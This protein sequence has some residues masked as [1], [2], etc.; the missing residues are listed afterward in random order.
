MEE[1]IE[2]IKDFVKNAKKE[3]LLDLAER[4][5]GLLEILEK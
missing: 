1:L 2:C 5:N 4:Y 3:K